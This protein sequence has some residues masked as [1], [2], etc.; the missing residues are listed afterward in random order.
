MS[1]T[2]RREPPVRGR[3]IAPLP[4]SSRPTPNTSQERQQQSQLPQAVRQARLSRPDRLRV[5]AS[6]QSSVQLQDTY[7]RNRHAARMEHERQLAEAR[8]RQEAELHRLEMEARE[9]VVQKLKE[10]VEH[11]RILH[12][13]EQRA[14]RQF[15]NIQE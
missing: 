7:A 1:S 6:W 3:F 12:Q 14:F 11:N 13:I 8:M 5:G 10:E 15:Y 9:L 2:H 4:S